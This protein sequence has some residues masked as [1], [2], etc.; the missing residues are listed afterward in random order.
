M[1]QS[2]LTFDTQKGL[3]APDT[4]QVIAFVQNEFQKVFGNDINLDPSSAQGQL[5]T[6]LAAMISTKNTEV[7]KLANQF[8]P[9]T[10]QGT[11]QDALG[12][13]YFLE[14]KI[15]QPTIVYC[16]CT[17]LAGTVIPAGALVESAEGIRF[18]AQSEQ[19]IDE[20]QSI[21]MTFICET[22]GPVQVQPNTIT[23]IITVVPGWDTVN[24]PSAGI[25][26]RV[27]ETQAEFDRRRY[28]SVSKNAHGTA[29]SLY[30][31]LASIN[32]VL[33]VVVLENRTNETIEEAGVSIE[34]HSVYISIFG[35]TDDE[36]SETI[37]NKLGCGCGTTGDVPVT[38]VAADYFDAVYTFNINRPEELSIYINIKIKETDKTP[39]TI[40]E[41]IKE[42]VLQN[43]NGL[44]SASSS[45]VRM[46]E[47]L[48]ASRF[49]PTILSQNVQELLDVGISLDNEAFESVLFIPADKFPTLKKENITVELEKKV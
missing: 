23:K 28:A 15:A 42:A 12:R 39:A 38:Y 11:F 49:Y 2:N 31:A 29:A 45:R 8:N 5:I 20:T 24:N 33:D 41:D 35:G 30:G 3:L 48:Y 17:G 1:S 19:V 21:A 4:D 37:Y 18:Y 32:N 34:G 7:L 9:L 27:E 26:G 25:V 46:A 44:D 13:I 36:I 10:A 40:D 47:N 43:F 6:T 16:E 14:R 22:T